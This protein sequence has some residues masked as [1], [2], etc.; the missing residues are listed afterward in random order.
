K[1]LPQPSL[2]QCVEAH[3]NHKRRGAVVLNQRVEGLYGSAEHDAFE[4]RGCL[5]QRLD[6]RQRSQAVE[7][8][9]ARRIVKKA[10][11]DRHCSCL[12]SP[13]WAVDDRGLM[14]ERVPP[15][16]RRAVRLLANL[17]ERFGENVDEGRPARLVFDPL[18]LAD[19]VSD[20]NALGRLRDLPYE[21]F[22]DL[23]DNPLGL[24]FGIALV[25]IGEAKDVGFV[26]APIAGV[27]RRQVRADCGL[28]DLSSL[29]GHGLPRVVA[30]RLA[31]L[32]HAEELNRSRKQLCRTAWPARYYRTDTLVEPRAWD[33]N[34]RVP[35][36][37]DGG[38]W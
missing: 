19:V 22:L 1:T 7:G 15:L 18:Q 26:I 29:S 10:A 35:P 36:R 30:Q 16:L 34:V 17:A 24:C 5:Q 23:R 13:Q 32:G 38:R 12:R 11:K 2:V 14:H 25:R 28:G 21:S 8:D 9:L 3:R 4:F 27:V 6:T 37:S 31:D 20:T 33:V